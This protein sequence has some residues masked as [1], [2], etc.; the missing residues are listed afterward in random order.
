MKSNNLTQEQRLALR[1][2]RKVANFERANF[3]GIGDR[4]RMEREGNNT[5]I[6]ETKTEWID[7][8]V[9][10]PERSRFHEV[11]HRYT[12]TQWIRDRT[13]LYRESW[14]NP[15]IDELLGEKNKS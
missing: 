6:I 12:L 9:C 4:L 10:S 11:E 3:D 8:G 5:F 14:L 15:V 7:C 13:K 2:I 1:E